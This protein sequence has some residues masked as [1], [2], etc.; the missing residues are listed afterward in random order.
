MD[1][2]KQIAGVE[3]MVTQGIDV[4]LLNPVDTKGVRPALDA[5]Q[6]AGVPIVNFDA[7]VYDSDMV[8]SIL[9]SNNY[10]A[11][12]VVGERVAQDFPDGC[13]IAIF[14]SPT[15]KSTLDLSLIHICGMP[16]KIPVSR[17]T[18]LS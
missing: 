16:L 4:L 17:R 3:D 11:G 8:E 15:A 7:D 6:E 18:A 5:C 2:A 10:K 1:Q 14:D 9:V 13:T 12:Q